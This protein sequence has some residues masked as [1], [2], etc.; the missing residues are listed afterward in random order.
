VSRARS[1]SN[2]R[3][4]SSSSCCCCSLICDWEDDDD[5]CSR[6]CKLVRRFVIEELLNVRCWDK[7]RLPDRWRSSN[8]IE[9]SDKSDDADTVSIRAG[10]LTFISLICG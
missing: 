10:R 7:R 4:L 1:I 6:F 8:K 3:L 2:W 5:G 9:Q